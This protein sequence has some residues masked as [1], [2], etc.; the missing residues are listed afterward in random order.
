MHKP[1][2]S[3]V[4]RE[5]GSLIE[6]H[7]RIDD[8]VDTGGLSCV[9]KVTDTRTE[10]T[11]ALKEY[12]LN[13]GSDLTRAER[14]YNRNVRLNNRIEAEA[15]E[16]L[17]I[18]YIPTI[19]EVVDRDDAMII[20]MDYIDGQSLTSYIRKEGPLD[21][22]LGGKVAIQLATFLERIHSQDP[23][24]I[25]RD[26]KPANIMML[27][28]NETISIIDFG[29][30][31][32]YEAGQNK[33]Q[34]RLGTPEYASPELRGRLQMQTDPRSDIYSFG[35]TLFEIMH[36]TSPDAIDEELSEQE[37]AENR[38]H[39]IRACIEQEKKK[40]REVSKE[41]LFRIALKCT[42]YF[43]EER[44]QTATELLH[45]LRHEQE[46]NEKYQKQAL[47]ELIAKR[48][49]VTSVV[50]SL[51][52]AAVR[53]IQRRDMDTIVKILIGTGIGLSVFGIVLLVFT[54]MRDKKDRGKKSREFNGLVKETEKYEPEVADPD[55]DLDKTRLAV[56]SE[57]VDDIRYREPSPAAPG[58]EKK[59][60]NTGK[61]V[62]KTMN[63]QG[64][65]SSFDDMEEREGE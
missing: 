39:E 30:I 31:R 20:V 19:H 42:C 17:Q 47:R 43:P 8:I 44:F 9:Y 61:F 28:D 2:T 27:E 50:L 32:S 46:I 62:I 63:I 58:E 7:Y 35:V 49:I 40:R 57:K 51:L 11:W 24:I 10:K 29:T 15:L 14:R 3:F 38:T 36:G 41:G 4:A 21:R 59:P 1:T 37:R 12:I 48:T 23:P 45:A 13:Q 54:L 25:H 6:G 18:P 65:A 64:A 60:K 16:K 55:D 52:L 26:I 33:D 22:V 34:H 56:N 53:L 5:E